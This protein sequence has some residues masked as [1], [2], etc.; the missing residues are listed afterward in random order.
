MASMACR[1]CVA[2]VSIPSSSS[3]LKSYPVPTMEYMGRNGW[4]VIHVPTYIV[5]NP[6]SGYQPAYPSYPIHYPP[7]PILNSMAIHGSLF[8][9][10]FIPVRPPE[11]LEVNK[12]SL[13]TYGTSLKPN[14]PE[15]DPLTSHAST[16]EHSTA[17][18]STAP[19]VVYIHPIV[20]R[21]GHRGPVRTSTLQLHTNIINSSLDTA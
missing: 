5:Y 8:T 20:R 13:R 3:S 4:D 12:R 1:W 19:T 16:P 17:Q 14:G 2:A 7:A 18:R 6:L 21:L 9:S 15:S 10:S 11:L